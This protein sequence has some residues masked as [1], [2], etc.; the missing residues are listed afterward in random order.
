M[1]VYLYEI[2][3]L[4]WFLI[5]LV[6]SVLLGL[7]T[8]AGLAMAGPYL[9]REVPIAAIRDMAQPHAVERALNAEA[10][11]TTACPGQG[12]VVRYWDW[13]PTVEVTESAVHAVDKEK[14]LGF[15]GAE[16][17][18]GAD[19]ALAQLQPW[20]RLLWIRGL[21][22]ISVFLAAIFPM[23]ACWFA[24]RRHAAS[25]RDDGAPASNG[26]RLMWMW[27]VGLL[28][29]LDGLLI[30]APWIVAMVPWIALVVVIAAALVFF[31]RSSMPATLP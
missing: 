12:Y 16:L 3:K 20:L 26:M 2:Y 28:A 14:N 25:L 4:F 10:A 24:G 6:P 27:A 1:S 22:A 31:V 13:S 21:A 19:R 11:F 18:T 29:F 7:L 15:I 8:G 5:E 30:G 9:F 17:S 23:S